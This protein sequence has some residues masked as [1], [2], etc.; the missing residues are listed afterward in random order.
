MCH[1]PQKV[2]MTSEDVKLTVDDV[3]KFINACDSKS[4]LEKV[5][6]MLAARWDTLDAAEKKAKEIKNDAF[7]FDRFIFGPFRL[8]D[9][10][11]VFRHC[12]QCDT[13]RWSKDQDW[14]DLKTGSH[15]VHH[16]CETC[17]SRLYCLSISSGHAEIFAYRQIIAAFVRAVKS[18]QFVSM[19]E[20][21]YFF[22]EW[23][24][25]SN[26]I[27]FRHCV[28]CRVDRKW[29]QTDA[30]SY[31]CKSCESHKD[32]SQALIEAVSKE[33]AGEAGTVL[34]DMQSHLAF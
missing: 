9:E 15:L 23:K 29:D 18:T 16:F 31:F 22:G 25:T 3:A 11:V 13:N 26:N 8:V 24:T 7:R 4:I 28:R 34:A 14:K 19:N 20:I 12:V 33:L 32:M 30:N 21:K 1:S 10:A 17:T 6:D 2:F 27:V 5:N